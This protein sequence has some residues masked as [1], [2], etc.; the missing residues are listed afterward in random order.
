MKVIILI[1]ITLGLMLTPVMVDAQEPVCWPPE[2]WRAE[3]HEWFAWQCALQRQY[4]NET[5]Y[6]LGAF[7]DFIGW[8]EMRAVN[9][10]YWWLPIPC[11]QGYSYVFC[12]SN[13]ARIYKG[14]IWKTTRRANRKD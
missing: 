4:T 10:P 14:G 9:E 1:L 6:G 7:I 11:W 5:G 13:G 2:E 12:D 8:A 3:Y